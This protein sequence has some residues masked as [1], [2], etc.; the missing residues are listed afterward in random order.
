MAASERGTA[1]IPVRWTFRLDDAGRILQIE[2][3]P[4]P[5]SGG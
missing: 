1:T 2:P 5:D 4:D 3:G